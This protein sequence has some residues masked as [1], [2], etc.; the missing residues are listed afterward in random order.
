MGAQV[1]SRIRVD[2]AITKLVQ[3]VGQHKPTPE[4][5]LEP[6]PK[7]VAR[8]KP[9]PKEQNVDGIRVFDDTAPVNADGTIKW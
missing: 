2:A 4:A 6:K 3:L 8:P 1:L 5:K 9:T 7:P